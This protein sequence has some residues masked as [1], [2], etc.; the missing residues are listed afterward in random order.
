MKT[1]L[2]KFPV[3]V[4]LCISFVIHG[5]NSSKK[6]YGYSFEDFSAPYNKES[7][8][9]PFSSK[10]SKVKLDDIKTVISDYNKNSVN[11]GGHYILY[12]V[13]NVK[14]V[15]GDED[16]AWLEQNTIIIDTKT[17]I[18]YNTPFGRLGD[19]YCETGYSEKIF[20][21]PVFLYKKNSNLL[22]THECE[23][24]IDIEIDHDI[25]KKLFLIKIYKWDGTKFQLLDTKKGRR[26]TKN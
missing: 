2:A 20:E 8:K 17:G 18:A 14:T 3:A 4:L 22:I 6:Y 19:D 21:N 10:K 13:E 26:N 11:F 16:G 9:T 23:F 5:Q 1:Y 24:E 15:E 25:L 12:E 7:K